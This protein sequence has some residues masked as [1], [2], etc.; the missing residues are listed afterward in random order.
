MGLAQKIPAL[1]EFCCFDLKSGL[2]FFSFV[3]CGIVLGDLIGTTWIIATSKPF[4]AGKKA[5]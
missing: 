2:E 3:I 1:K 4:S 5:F